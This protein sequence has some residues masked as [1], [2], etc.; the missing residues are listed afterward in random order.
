MEK[1]E[2][3]KKNLKALLWLREKNRTVNR[4]CSLCGDCFFYYDLRT[5]MNDLLLGDAWFCLRN[6]EIKQFAKDVKDGNVVMASIG[7]NKVDKDPY[8]I[9]N[10]FSDI[11]DGEYFVNRKV[12]Y[13]SVRDDLFLMDSSIRSGLSNYGNHCKLENIRP[14]NQDEAEV[15]KEAVGQ[16]NSAFNLDSVFNL[17]SFLCCSK[18]IWNSYDEG[19]AH[20]IFG[21]WDND[22]RE[23]TYL[24]FD[25]LG[26]FN[27]KDVQVKIEACQEIARQAHRLTTALTGYELYLKDYPELDFVDGLVSARLVK[28]DMAEI[29]KV[30]EPTLTLKELFEM[31]A[32]DREPGDW[33]ICIK[34]LFDTYIFNTTADNRNNFLHEFFDDRDTSNMTILKLCYHNDGVIPSDFKGIKHSIT[35]CNQDNEKTACFYVYL[36]DETAM[37][38]EMMGDVKS[39]LDVI[40]N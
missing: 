15:I 14:L 27:P 26:M 1:T 20:N 25:T 36:W 32:G 35:W 22:K 3:S 9:T 16:A 33:A 21:D 5:L 2:L 39:F 30:C 19:F 34:L 17:F 37:T 8:D 28:N 7:K 38:Y 40:K 12:S 23:R 13:N 31:V 10:K 24:G 4:G 18:R 11:K 29:K 6:E